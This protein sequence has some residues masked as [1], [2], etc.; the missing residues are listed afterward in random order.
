MTTGH[1]DVLIGGSGADVLSSSGSNNF[2]TLIAGSGKK[3]LTTSGVYDTLIGGSGADTLTTSGSGDVL[4]AAAPEIGC[5]RAAPTTC[6]RG[7]DRRGDALS[8]TGADDTLIGGSGA[9]RAVEC[10]RRLLL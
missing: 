1:G 10:H 3:T 7:R 2:N 6:F 5:R 4:I 8:T 9:R